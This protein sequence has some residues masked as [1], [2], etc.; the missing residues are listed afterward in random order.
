[1]G[2][3]STEWSR[4]MHD[5]IGLRESPEEINREVVELMLATG[6]RI[7]EAVYLRAGG[8]DLERRQIVLVKNTSRT[9]T[10]RCR[11]PA[12]GRATAGPPR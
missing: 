6:L 5:V 4:Y 7:Q 3:S 2:M 10:N 12:C 1:M 9:K 8:I 11:K